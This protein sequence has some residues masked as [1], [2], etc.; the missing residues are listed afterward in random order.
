MT[1]RSQR[2]HKEQSPIG[3]CTPTSTQILSIAIYRILQELHIDRDYGFY[4][5][6]RSAPDTT[7]SSQDLEQY[8]CLKA[9]INE[10]FRSPCG[11][12]RSDSGAVI[13]TL[14]YD[15]F[16]ADQVGWKY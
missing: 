8:P 9:V 1:S 2:N 14:W 15:C 7:Y 5:L 6:K 4:S 12:I 16:F 11:K 10:G 3:S 13:L